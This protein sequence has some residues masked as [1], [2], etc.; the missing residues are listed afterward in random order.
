[1]GL[2]NELS[3]FRERRS[4]SELS[5][6][7][8]ALS[9][10]DDLRTETLSFF[11]IVSQVAYWNPHISF[12]YRHYSSL[13]FQVILALGALCIF[14]FHKCLTYLTLNSNKMS[15]VKCIVVLM[16]FNWSIQFSNRAKINSKVTAIKL[17][18]FINSFMKKKV[19]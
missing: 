5:N 11:L 10:I 2:F 16:A 13:V 17:W 14:G 12:L 7:R 4:A 3:W 19:N 8:L 15:L 18:L 9:L 6:G 1:M